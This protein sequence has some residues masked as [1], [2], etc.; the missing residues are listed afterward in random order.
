ME[1]GNPKS[2]LYLMEC[3]FETSQ[4][5]IQGDLDGGDCHWQVGNTC[6]RPYNETSRDQVKVLAFQ[7]NNDISDVF[8]D[9]TENIM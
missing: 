8:T 3:V 7:W 6:V 2:P 9:V 5:L 1:R 4:N